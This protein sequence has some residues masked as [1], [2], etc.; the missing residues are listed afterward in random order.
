MTI[1]LTVTSDYPASVGQ[2]LTG[3]ATFT[4]TTDTDQADPVAVTFTLTSS[5]YTTVEHRSQTSDA[6]LG[7]LSPWSAWSAQNSPALSF[8]TLTDWTSD[9]THTYQV[10]FTADT[11]GSYTVTFAAKISGVTQSS[12]TSPFVVTST[13]VSSTIAST[14]IS[15]EVTA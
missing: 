15:V 8:G 1:T 14:P 10:R 11:P 5:A 6:T 13:T 12:D 9:I 3:S 4:L 2:G 7:V